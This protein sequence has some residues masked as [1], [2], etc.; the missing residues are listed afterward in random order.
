M[1]TSTT[2][3]N[4]NGYGNDS[5][6]NDSRN[7][8]KNHDSRSSNNRND[9]RS[10]HNND[11]I[12]RANG[13][14]S[15][16]AWLDDETTSPASGTPAWMDAP[17]TG[18]G[19]GGD[20]AP[21]VDGIQAWKAQMKEMERK[22]KAKEDEANGNVPGNSSH[23]DSIP[24]TSSGPPPGLPIPS[25]SAPML[26][27]SSVANGPS[28]ETKSDVPVS[29]P[30]VA[31]GG[32][33]SRFAKFFDGKQPSASTGGVA[34]TPTLEGLGSAKAETTSPADKESMSRLMGMLQGS[35]VSPRYIRV[36]C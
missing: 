33:S 16:P 12:S 24:E 17:A 22:E 19:T 18:T 1:R 13:G 8:D 2:N 30:V 10:T 7:H 14:G 15:R 29:V 28:T 11:R 27:P 4:S 23:G 34:T 20:N 36:D 9:D 6:N 25:Q 35:G 26:S 21:P 32:R 5:R 31:A 3:A